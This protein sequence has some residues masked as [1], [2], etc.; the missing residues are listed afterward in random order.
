MTSVRTTTSK[1]TTA[2][3]TNTTTA[4]RRKAVADAVAGA[5]ASL[6]AQWVFYPVDV[7]K[8][9]VQASTSTTTTSSSG[10]CCRTATKTSSDS[11]AFHNDPT[12]AQPATIS[13]TTT[14]GWKD[15]LLAGWE[16]KTLHTC[17]SSFCYFFVYSWLYSLWKRRRQQLRLRYLRERDDNGGAYPRA[18]IVISSST[19]LILSALAAMI[20]TCLTLPLDVLSS[21]GQ[22]VTRQ[23]N[24]IVHDNNR[25]PS[26]NVAVSHEDE[27]EDSP[28]HNGTQGVVNTG[29]DEGVPS[30]H[31]SD[32]SMRQN[33]PST[34]SDSTHHLT[35]L[36]SGLYP[37]LLLCLNPAIHYTLFDALKGRWLKASSN[38]DYRGANRRPA[39][40][41]SKQQLSMPAAFVLGLVAK[42]VATVVTY[43]LIRVKV[44]LM[45]TPN[46]PPHHPGSTLPSSLS[47]SSL[48]QQQSLG[49][50]LIN[51]YHRR[52]IR[53]GWY[54]GFELQVLHTALKS[55]LLMAVRER[56]TQTTRN[57]ILLGNK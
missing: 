6:V 8:T 53:R 44:L 16:L 14:G 50:C 42:F 17:A 7:Y 54:H 26:T 2:T 29:N 55:S 12:T 35:S 38:N 9:R 57:L 13:T 11:S 46:T 30:R 24:T 21:R 20:N 4:A 32:S 31:P 27:D 36:W 18:N 39:T 15:H 22:V 23:D 28:C 37:S 49:A 51:E 5:V 25:R 34:P 3:T 48:T 56:V 1:S 47:S 33:S 19:R 45:V 10:G 40:S 41:P 43:P 52:G